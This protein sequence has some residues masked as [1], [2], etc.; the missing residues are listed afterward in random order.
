MKAMLLCAGYGTRLG[1]L[2]R[3]LPKPMLPLNGQPMLAYLIAN[4]QRQGVDELA[5]NL[6]YKPE[7]IREHF[8]D[9]SPLHVRLI[10]SQED[11]LLGTAGALRKMETFFRSD[12]EFLV[13]YGDIVT[14]QDFRPMLDFHR[15]RSAL[16]TLL[17]HQRMRSN[18]IVTLDERGCVTQF[19]ERPA[20]HQRLSSAP[21]WV[22]SGVC[23]CAAAFLDRIPN[24]RP[25]DLARDIFPALAQTGRLFAFPLSGF[26]CAVDSE[27]RF[28]EAER[29]LATGL[30]R[31]FLDPNGAPA[32]TR[33]AP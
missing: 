13:H 18:S 12:P 3:E 14:D 19:L 15:E 16:A 20:E 30:C 1:A 8:G 23:V 5:V 33:S 22:N 27:H 29:A 7:L 17:V 24:D 2:T 25:C 21:S 28:A 9:G 10:Y 11:Q 31:S 26:R 32:R 4:L 6:H